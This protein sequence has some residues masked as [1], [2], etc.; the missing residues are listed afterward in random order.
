MARLCL[1]NPGETGMEPMISP[2]F[3]H[4]VATVDQF[5]SFLQAGLWNRLVRWAFWGKHGQRGYQ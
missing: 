1:Q 3:F 5:P 2:T 4:L